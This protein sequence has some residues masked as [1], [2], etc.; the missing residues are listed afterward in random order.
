[1][2]RWLLIALLV[3]LLAVAQDRYPFANPQQAQRFTQLTHH[4]RCLVC[5]NEDL[6]ASS[7]SLAMQLKDDLYQQVNAGYSNQAIQ[8]YFVNRYGDF[9][10]FKPPVAKRTWVLWYAPWAFLLLGGLVVWWRVRLRMDP[11]DKPRGVGREN[12]RAPALPTSRG[13][14]TE[15]SREDS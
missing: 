5:Q 12:N 4:F 9:V 10:L 13:L 1:M 3:P 2:R 11:A 6:A 7:A 8:D 14:S 15:S